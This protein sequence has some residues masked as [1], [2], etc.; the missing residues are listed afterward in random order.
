M[1]IKIDNKAA[2][3]A[4]VTPEAV[5]A[6]KPAAIQAINTLETGNGAGSDFL[7]WLHLPSSIDEA[8]LSAIEASAQLLRDECEYVIA[9]GIGGSYL[10]AKAVIIFVSAFVPCVINSYAG[11]KQTKAVHLWVAQ[12]FGVSRHKQLTTI[13]IPTA[14]PLIFTGLR[15]SLGTAW[16]TLCAAEMLAANKEVNQLIR[17]GLSSDTSTVD[18]RINEAAVALDRALLLMKFLQK[19]PVVGVIGGLSDFVYMERISDYAVLKY[20]RRFLVDQL[21]SGRH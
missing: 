10:G 19:I 3:T 4:T 21:R 17:K 1:N 13:A 18:E 8:Q 14:L 15:I 9:I 6:L 11:I 7:G 2:F 16:M 20:Q 12:T 5:E